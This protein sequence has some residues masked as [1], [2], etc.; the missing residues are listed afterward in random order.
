[1]ERRKS[2]DERGGLAVCRYTSGSGQPSDASHVLTLAMK[3]LFGELDRTTR[4]VSP[5]R[6]LKVRVWHMRG[7]VGSEAGNNSRCRVRG[8]RG[9]VGRREEVA[10]SNQSKAGGAVILIFGV[11]SHWELGVFVCA[12]VGY[13]MTRF[14][15]EKQQLRSGGKWVWGAMWVVA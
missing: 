15:P 11:H 2:V 1:M 5:Y 8:V 14:L 12:D 13:A 6:F 7:G 9:E 3:D 4:P 10:L